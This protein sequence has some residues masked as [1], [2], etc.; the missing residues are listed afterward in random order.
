LIQFS[1]SPG[2]LRLPSQA[3]GSRFA[4]LSS[5]NVESSRQSAITGGDVAKIRKIR[6]AASEFEALLIS[7]WWRT[8]KES[9]LSDGEDDNDPAKDTM[10]SLGIQTVSQAVADKGGFGIANLLVNSLL[11]TMAGQSGSKSKPVSA[12]GS[13]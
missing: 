5:S 10:D 12:V 7:N 1:N 13:P 9:A 6:K 3:G 8:M 4:S 2:Q 11:G